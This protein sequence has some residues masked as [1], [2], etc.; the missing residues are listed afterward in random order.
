[1]SN[2]GATSPIWGRGPPFKIYLTQILRNRL[3]KSFHTFAA[4][5]TFGRCM[6]R[7]KMWGLLDAFL[8]YRGLNFEFL[9]VSITPTFLPRG[10]DQSQIFF[11]RWKL[12]ANLHKI[13]YTRLRYL[14]SFRSYQGVEYLNFLVTIFDLVHLHFWQTSDESIFL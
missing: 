9:R 5:P 8:R 4:W 7:W 2:E 1:M 3:V 11:I 13:L 6:Q 14:S 12:K 10:G